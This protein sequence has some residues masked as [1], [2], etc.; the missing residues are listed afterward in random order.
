MR[1]LALRD[2]TRRIVSMGRMPDGAPDI[3]PEVLTAWTAALDELDGPL[4][5][6]EAIA[7]LPCFPPDDCTV[8]GLAWSL[9]HAIESAPYGPSFISELDDRSWWVSYLR[10]RA[11]RGGLI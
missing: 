1:Y 2:S 9:L 3:D 6:E 11:V 8:F 5:D 4:T 7:L 10:Q